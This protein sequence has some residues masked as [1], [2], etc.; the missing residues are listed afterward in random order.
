MKILVVG[1]GSMGK[2][3]IRLI[4]QAYKNIEIV[5]VDSNEE[6]R[7][8][9]SKLFEI[10]TTDNLK[11]ALKTKA[12]TAA[13]VCSSPLSH[14]SIIEECLQMRLHVFSEINLTDYKYDDLI[15]IADEN[16][17]KLFLSSTP[18][19]RNEIEYITQK[20]QAQAK[21]VNY[22]YHVGQ[23]LPDWHPWENFK[24]FFVNDAKTNG[25][26]ELFAIE[27]GWIINAFGDVVNITK[28][29]SKNSTLNIDYSDNYIVILEHKNG[30]KGVIVVDVVSRMPVRKLEVT[31]EELHLFWEGTPE[32]LR[33]YNI[34]F[35][36]LK[37]IKTYKQTEHNKHYSTN[38]IEDAYLEEIKEFFSYIEGS[39]LPRYSFEKDKSILKI[40][41]I[42]ER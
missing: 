33:N 24:D 26:R 41:D 25:C 8:S 4:M 37:T 14:A 27:L 5:G 35:K 7:K 17:C 32:S 6:R 42:I 3:R 29:K 10:E 30:H 36:Q 11:L 22:I 20:V 18:M 23:Y 9:I 2:R 28:V 40:V 12:Y 15:K 31:G 16:G 38:I 39:I 13:F 34:E 1:L 19:Y 21:P